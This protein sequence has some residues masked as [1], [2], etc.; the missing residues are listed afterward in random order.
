MQALPETEVQ[1]MGAGVGSGFTFLATAAEHVSKQ[2]ATE[3][4]AVFNIPNLH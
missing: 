4:A 2:M 3:T 1:P